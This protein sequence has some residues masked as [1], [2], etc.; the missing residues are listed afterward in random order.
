[1]GLGVRFEER[2]YSGGAM[3]ALTVGAKQRTAAGMTLTVWGRRPDDHDREAMAV[4][5]LALL[6]RK[7]A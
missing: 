5:M 2:S 7:A 4:D 6:D 1:M 3:L